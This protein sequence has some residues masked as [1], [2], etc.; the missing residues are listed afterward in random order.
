MRIKNILGWEVALP[1]AYGDAGSLERKFRKRQRVRARR[2]LD[3]A[4]IN[5]QLKVLSTER[6]RRNI[7]F[8]FNDLDTYYTLFEIQIGMK[9]VRSAYVKTILNRAFEIYKQKEECN[10]P[11]SAKICIDIA[12]LERT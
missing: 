9:E 4:L 12:R 6:V 5:E 8:D 7:Q 2:R 3:K 10:K 1:C 11:L